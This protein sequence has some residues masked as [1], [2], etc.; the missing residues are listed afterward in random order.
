MK[1]RTRN[2]L[3]SMLLVFCMLLS[4]LPSSVI[5]AEETEQTGVLQPVTTAVTEETV[6]AAAPSSPMKLAESCNI[7]R[8]VNEEVFMQS[9]HIAR[10]NAQETL[11]S[12]AF[13]N[14]DGT[15][16]VYYMDEEVKFINTDGTVQEKDITLTTAT[17]GYTTVCNDVK[18]NLPTNPANGISLV[19]GN[20]SAT[21]KPQ[22]RTFSKSPV[23]ENNT[24]TYPDYFG[25]GMDLVY[26]PTLSGVKEDIV[27]ESYTGVNSFTFMLNTRGLNLYQANGRYFLAPS[28]VSDMRIELGDIVSFDARGRFS[29]GTMTATTVMAGSLYQLTITV[30]EGF[31]TDENTTYPVSIDPTLEVSDNTH[32]A[33][34]I[35]DATLYSGVPGLNS[36]SWQYLHCGYYDS[37]YQVSRTA[38]MP[39][40]MM[41][42]TDFW[43][44]PYNGVTSA[45]FY[46]KEAGWTA[47]VTVN[48]HR[49]T[50]SWDENTITWSS[51]YNKYD[52]TVSASASPSYGN[53]AE[54]DITALVQ[55]WRYYEDYG[56]GF[57]LI[58]TNETSVDKTLYSS[59]SG[60]SNRPYVVVTYNSGNGILDKSTLE[61][62]EGQSDTLTLSGVSGT[63]T[64]TSSNTAVATVN[65]SGLVTAIKAGTATITASVPGYAPKTCVVYV[66]IPDGVYQIANRSAG[67]PMTTGGGINDTAGG[68]YTRFPA[69]SIPQRLYWM[70]KITHLGGGNY[71]IRPYYKLDRALCVNGSYAGICNT[72]YT[73]SLD[74]VPASARWTITYTSRGYALKQNGSNA[75]SLMAAEEGVDTGILITVGTY[76]STSDQHHWGLMEIDEPPR[77]VLLF[78]NNGVALTTVPTRYV[79]SNETRSLLQMG[80]EVSVYSDAA[81]TP[82]I[83]TWSSSNAHVTVNRTT[84]VVTGVSAGTATITGTNGYG[85]VSFPVT[86]LPVAN[87]TYMIKNKGSELFADIRGGTQVDGA[88]VY[89]KSLTSNN[90]Q[91]WIIAHL[92]DG[93]Y[94]I[95]SYNSA[96]YL[97]VTDDSPDQYTSIVLRTGSLTDGM[98]WK[99]T[100]TSSG[101]YKFTP[102]TGEANNRVLALDAV[103]GTGNAA[104]LYQ[105]NYSN[106]ASY[107]DEWELIKLGNDAYLLGIASSDHDHS[108]VFGTI[109]QDIN[110]LGYN[111][112]NINCT[113]SIS[114]TNLRSAMGQCKIYVSRSHGDHTANETYILLDSDESIRFY[115]SD[116]YNFSTNT[117]VIDLSDC[118]LMLFVGCYTGKDDRYN[119]PDA[120]VAAGSDYAIGFKESI[121]CGTANDWTELFFQYLS[122]GKSVDKAASL[123]ADECFNDDPRIESIHIAH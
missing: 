100:G 65:S 24:V 35:E 38:F 109:G 4:L 111:G 64:W 97:G 90:F 27:L 5:A 117:A 101:A 53:Y 66:T 44:I 75:K 110:A 88:V 94:S 9:N 112:V 30:D 84:G 46:V 118:D 14:S 19:Y 104:P 25:E 95:R 39:I 16:T 87:G 10:L 91:K 79:A 52:S 89:Q 55:Y 13:L 105:M 62:D 61:I 21:L 47:G 59:E 60:S 114:V 103:E 83:F 1:Q 67:Y 63:V 102:L 71:V 72:G 2:K 116:I 86:V 69:D 115:A 6:A 68:I 123:A 29:V 77:G 11:S 73:N 96:C 8:Y 7:L 51:H 99:I 106:D 18:L 54:F 20:Y 58:S 56:N 98:K 32:G 34:A 81:T 70:W 122:E 107:I 41:D 57:M 26:T 93:T 22:G 120:A 36:G 85:S 12:Y 92:G 50:A 45:K 113:S 76:S 49:I 78:Y 40:G 108:T 42:D 15:T 48:L 23:L 43:D 3:T 80:L 121:N 28:K 37:T 82:Q 17:G 33:G 119:L 74:A 31:L